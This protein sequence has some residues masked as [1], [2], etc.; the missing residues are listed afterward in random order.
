MYGAIANGGTFYYPNIVREVRGPQG[1]LL[2]RREP[3]PGDRLFE[4]DTCRQMLAFLEG[5]VEYGTGR[6]AAIDGVR[7][8]GKTG[9]AQIWDPKQKAFLKDEFV[10]SFVAVA[11]IEAPQFVVHVRVNKPK[12][13]D[14]G[15][16]TALPAA[17][18]VLEAALRLADDM[19]A[20]SRDDRA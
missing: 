1:A 18:Q 15:S 19:G 3:Y 4:P 17:K 16:D 5:A 6:A 14:H 20:P 11:P 7:V 10:M 2:R 9:T 8:G 12:V 13:G